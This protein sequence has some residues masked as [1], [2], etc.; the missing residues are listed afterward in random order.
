MEDASTLSAS[1]ETNKLSTNFVIGKENWAESVKCFICERGFSKLQGIFEHHCRRCGMAVC[2][3]CSN[4]KKEDHRI[5]DICMHKRDSEDKERR[6]EDLL[7]SRQERHEVCQDQFLR[8]EKRLEELVAK[9]SERKWKVEQIKLGQ[10]R[11]IKEL[12]EEKER[13]DGEL[14]KGQ[15]ENKQLKEGIVDQG[16]VLVEKERKIGSLK[17]RILAL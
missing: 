8:D 4:N 15:E 2:G 5:C 9:K 6:K 13:L 11:E 12:E 14:L 3:N 10:D 1:S 7:A 16:R 17:R